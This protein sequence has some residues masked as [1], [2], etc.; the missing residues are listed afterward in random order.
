MHGGEFY[1]EIS[2][3][4]LIEVDKLKGKNKKL[5][6]AIERTLTITRQV[7][8]DGSTPLSPTAFHQSRRH[9]LAPEPRTF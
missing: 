8:P 2:R 6:V 9:G 7:I 3:Y 1:V 4:G 5:G